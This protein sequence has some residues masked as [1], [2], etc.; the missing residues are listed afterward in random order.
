M[1]VIAKKL[2]RITQSIINKTSKEFIDD[3]VVLEIKRLLLHSH[4][5]VKEISYQLNFDEPTNL[6]KYFKKHT[7]IS[8]AG[9]KEK[10]K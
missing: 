10:Q 2:N 7:G 4:E 9:F 1:N 8:P 6:V 5:S 3:R